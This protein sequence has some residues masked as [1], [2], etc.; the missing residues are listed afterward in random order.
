MSIYNVREMIVYYIDKKDFVA[1]KAKVNLRFQEISNSSLSEIGKM[2]GNYYYRVFKK[3]LK[4]NKSIGVAAYYNDDFVGCGWMKLKG[5]KDLF[6][7]LKSIKDDQAYLA[8]FHVKNEY[9][10]NGIYPA[11]L[12]WLIESDKAKQINQFYIAMSKTNISSQKSIEKMN[13]KFLYT[14][15][16]Y[17][18]MRI[19][20]N[21]T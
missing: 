6:F 3:V 19:T 15:K 9:R 8:S 17:R 13:P 5:A 16:K 10:G 2:M 1:N 18:F 14:E 21:K 11:M 4:E 7:K 12:T 20:L